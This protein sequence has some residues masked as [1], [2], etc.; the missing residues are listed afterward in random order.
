MKKIVPLLLILFFVLGMQPQIAFAAENS[1]FDQDL[2]AYLNKVSTE[3]GFSV[4][5]EAI[6]KALAGYENT[7]SDFTTVDEINILLGEVIQ[8]DYSNLSNIYKKYNLNQASLTKLLSEYGEELEDYI[9]LHNLDTA[10]AFYV[11]GTTNITPTPTQVPTQAPEGSTDTSETGYNGELIIYLADIS[12]IRGF[13]VSIDAIN[14]YLSEYDM[15]TADFTSVEELK[16]YL[17]EVIT[18]DLSNL[19]YFNTKYNMD[20][21]MIL[22]LVEDNGENMNDYIFMDQIDEL[23]WSSQEDPDFG[24]DPTILLGYL[25][26]IG[27]TQAELQNL[28]NHFMNNEEYFSS[29]EVQTKIEEISTR[30]IAFAQE[31][32]AKG[33]ADSN[34]KM[35]D[36]E[37]KEFVSFYEEILSLAKLKAVV[38]ISKDGVDQTISIFDLLKLEEEEMLNKDLK[39]AIYNM[40][41][42]L[43]ADF[44]V[45]SDFIRDNLGGVIDDVENT[46][47]G[48]QTIQTVKGGKLPKTASNDLAFVLLGLVVTSVGVYVYRKVR[49]DKGEISQEQA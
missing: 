3:R 35:S 10:L 49:N 31:L 36:T 15:S 14:K 39:V 33:E 20:Q 34:Y 9:Y 11:Q 13:E 30:M 2:A 18:K 16:D 48:I 47:E 8:A 42:E 41:S 32:V 38:S 5:Q 37:L 21:Q 22:Q 23:V 43:L 45:T 19:D 7:I 12:K 25:E 26:Q 4:N 6:D 27:L 28:Q 29:A 46:A 44:V 24:I 17:G 40:D 1:T